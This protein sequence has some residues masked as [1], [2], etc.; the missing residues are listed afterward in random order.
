MTNKQ[1]TFRLGVEETCLGLVLC[2]EIIFSHSILKNLEKPI[3]DPLLEASLDTARRSLKARGL[4]VYDDNDQENLLPELAS[5]L[6][7]LASFD[8]SLS[9]TRTEK[10][11]SQTEVI[12]LRSMGDFVSWTTELQVVYNLSLNPASTTRDYIRQ[13]FNDFGEKNTIAKNNKQPISADGLTQ[14]ISAVKGGTD[15]EEL[16]LSSG[17]E[18][19]AAKEFKADMEKQAYRASIIWTRAGSRHVPDN[20]GAIERSALFLVKG[21]SR[22]W[23]IEFAKFSDSAS[24]QA[25]RLAKQDFTRVL[26]ETMP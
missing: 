8:S 16:L 26:M 2:N 13:K 9:I 15:F 11:S 6:K 7:T 5:T 17:W 4:L 24:G 1:T 18:A 14:I 19:A 10:L 21:K 23:V 22:C 12:H 3:P 25:Y 20:L